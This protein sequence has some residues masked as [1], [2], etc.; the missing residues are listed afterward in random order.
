MA[1]GAVAGN[2]KRIASN[3]RQVIWQAGMRC[4]MVVCQEDILFRQG[5]KSGGILTVNDL[6]VTAI[7]KQDYDYVVQH[8]NMGFYRGPCR[9]G[10]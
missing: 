7:L 8:R 5:I 1:V 6:L 4:G 10:A 3:D 2:A 9:G